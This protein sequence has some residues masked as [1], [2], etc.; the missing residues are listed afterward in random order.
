M[1]IV[2]ALFFIASAVGFRLVTNMSANAGAGDPASYA[3]MIGMVFCAALVLPRRIA[4]PVALGALLVS[5]I[6]LNLHYAGR[7]EGETFWSLTLA[8]WVLVNYIL[9]ALIFGVGLAFSKW[10]NVGTLFAGTIASVLVFYVLSNTASWAASPGYVKTLAGWWQAQTVGLPG[11]PPSYLFLRDQ[12]AGNVAFA[13]LFI[14]LV[15]QP[16]M[17]GAEKVPSPVT[18]PEA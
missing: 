14:L 3:P 10:R 4:L 6:V 15:L 1:Q 12:L 8:P 13:S 5:D 18:A 16:R 17:E 9:Y 2:A 11:F 7:M